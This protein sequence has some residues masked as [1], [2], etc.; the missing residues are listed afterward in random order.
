MTT[1]A[2]STANRSM[3]AVPMAKLEGISLIDHLWNRLSGTYGGRWLKD[4]PDMQSIENW[5]AA[6]AEAFDEE[7]LTPQDV[8]EGLRACRR[9]SPDW[10][11]SVGEFIRACRPTLEPEVAFYTAVAGMAARHNG[12]PGTWP[13]PAIFWAAV[14]VGAHD[15]QHCPYTTM[16]ARWERSLNEVLARGE[17]KPVPVIVKALPAPAITATSRA[18]AEEQMRK[19]GETGIMNQ[20]GR[21]PMRGWKRIIAETEDPNGKRFSPGIVA[22]A[23]NALRLDA[24]QGARS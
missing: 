10:P 11:P 8:A 23:R 5:K 1:V 4:F 15:L 7:N 21:D 6:W 3:W 9:M 17:W 16:K 20:S 22:M 18:Q 14:E 19:I 2:Q 24:G 13:H 12:E